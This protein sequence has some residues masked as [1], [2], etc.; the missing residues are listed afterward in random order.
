[1][2]FFNRS[3]AGCFPKDIL[4]TLLAVCNKTEATGAPDNSVTGSK[5]SAIARVECQCWAPS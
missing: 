4:K 2:E 1:M 5:S 3:V